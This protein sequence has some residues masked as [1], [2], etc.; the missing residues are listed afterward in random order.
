MSE[1]AVLACAL[2]FAC[3]CPNGKKIERP[4]VDPG[5]DAVVAHLQALR[6]RVDNI[7]ADTRADVW[8]GNDRANLSVNIAA[9]WGGRLRFQA[10]DPNDALAADLASD[11]T[12]YC[13]VDVH[14]GC[15]SC[16]PATPENVGRLLRMMLQPDEVVA[17]MLGG[18][19]VLDGDQQLT[20]DAGDGREVLDIAGPRCTQHIE[21]D[22]RERRW[23]VLESKVTCDRDV[24]KVTN[25]DF[26]V[27][28]AK[29]GREV[30][31]PGKSLFEQKFV[32]TDGKSHEESMVIEWRS[33]N[34][35]IEV[36]PVLF[37]FEP[38]ALPSCP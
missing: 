14:A 15:S 12:S 23:D 28:K 6:E 37:M 10:H 13:F 4:Y 26:R 20:W 34:A 25:K 35:N 38:P 30:R 1:S 24:W 5:A 33:V 3:G 16:G 27:V 19:P 7:S 31:L 36:K 11:G 9:A 17:I 22:G 8:V 21:L 2:L 32:G 29:D 18:T